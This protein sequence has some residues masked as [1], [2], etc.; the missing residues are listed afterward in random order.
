MRPFS[1]RSHFV[2]TGRREAGVSLIELL[3]SLAIGAVLIFGAIKAYVDSRSAYAINETIAHMQEAARYAI[4]AM[5]PDLRMANY[6]G[7]LKGTE[8]IAGQAGE[9]DTQFS[10]AGNAARECG[11]NFALDLENNIEGT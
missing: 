4:S 2:P 10:L 7:L 3:V 8:S 11:K 9:S 1:E 5:E 6:W